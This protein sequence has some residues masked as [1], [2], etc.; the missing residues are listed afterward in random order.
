MKRET[1][2]ETFHLWRSWTAGFESTMCRRLPETGPQSAPNEAAAKESIPMLVGA[3]TAGARSFS[4][5]P[6][7]DYPMSADGPFGQPFCGS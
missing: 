4:S 5:E 7:R 1:S 2:D 3:P 6:L